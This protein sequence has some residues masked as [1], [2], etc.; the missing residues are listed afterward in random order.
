MTLFSDHATSGHSE[1]SE[2]EIMQL[3][4]VVTVVTGV[5]VFK[6]AG[7]VLQPV[8][9]QV[10]ELVAA[11]VG[12]RLRRPPAGNRRLAGVGVAEQGRNPDRD[13]PLAQPS[14]QSVTQPRRGSSQEIDEWTHR[15][16]EEQP[17]D[18]PIKLF[19]LC[20]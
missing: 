18:D 11:D 17:C 4:S 13:D 14:P 1:I 15:H 8:L 5:T 7:D 6:Q 9:A 12:V 10:V 3:T 20:R 19:Y 2:V 16:Q